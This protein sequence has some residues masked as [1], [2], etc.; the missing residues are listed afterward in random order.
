ME[1]KDGAGLH[2]SAYKKYMRSSES[3]ALVRRKGFVKP[4]PDAMNN[5]SRHSTFN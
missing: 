1:E 5:Y 2:T 3:P 4:A